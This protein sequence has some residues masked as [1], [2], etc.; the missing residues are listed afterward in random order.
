MPG[1][2]YLRGAFTMQPASW[3]DAVPLQVASDGPGSPPDDWQEA[4]SSLQSA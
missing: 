1:E 2:D 3:L 4:L